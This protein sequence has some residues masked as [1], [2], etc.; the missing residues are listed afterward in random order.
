MMARFSSATPWPRLLSP[1]LLLV[2]LSLFDTGTAR[3]Q[4]AGLGPS[5]GRE[6]MG[7]GYP[8]PEYY[9]ALEVYRSGDLEK[10]MDA[11]DIAV[12]RTR[13]DIN[14]HWI[15]AIPVFAMM[16][17]CQYRLGDLEGAMQ[18]LDMSLKIAIRYRGWLGRPVWSEVL[19]SQFQ[20]SPKQ[21]LW[22]EANAVNR[23]PV[24][25]TIKFYSGEQLTEATLAQGGVI[26]ELNIKPIDAIEILRGLAIA[27]YRRRIILGP[28]AEGDALATQLLDSTKYPAG[29]QLP[30]AR[31]LI[32][33]MRAAER[34][35]AM[36]DERTVSD[37]AENATY[38]GGVHPI[39]PITGL[40]A[41]SALAGSDKPAAAIPLCLAVTNQAASMDYFE[42]VGEALQL[43]AGC[44]TAK[45]AAVVQQAGQVAAT[46]LLRKSRLAALHCLIASADAAVTA[47]DFASATAR[48]GEAKAIAMRRDVLQPRLDAYGAYVAARL[49]TRTATPGGNPNV[50]GPWEEGLSQIF[51]FATNSRIRKRSLI[52]M[53]RLYQLQR[54]RLALGRNLDGQSADVLLASYADDPAI[55]VWRRDPVDAI[56]G[57][58]ADRDLL[59]L[60][61]LRT[62]ASRESGQDVLARIEDL[63]AGRIRS[64]LPLGGRV[65]QVRALA[66]MPDELLEKKIVEF[67]NAADKPIRDLRTAAKAD[68]DAK[69]AAGADPAM[70]QAGLDRL[71]ANAWA[72]ALDR[73]VLPVV[74]P[75]ALD[76]KQPASVLPDDVG[77]L[78]FCQ[79]GNLIHA[80]LC[81]KQKSTYWT[82][83]GASRVA[84]EIAALSRGIGAAPSRG[85]RLPE[86]DGWR[87]DAIKFRDRLIATGTGAL[88][89]GRL[90][91]IK[92]LVVIPD[93]LLW[94]V[95]FELLPTD[96]RD[97]PLLGDSIDVVYAAT[98]A[99]AIYPTADKT[100]SPAIAVT[101]GKFFAP[102]EAET[103]AML[104]QTILD[105]IH[106][107]AAVRLPGDAMIPTSQSGNVAGHLVVAE[108]TTPNPASVL[109]SPLAA[110]ETSMRQGRL[111]SWLGFPPGTPGSVFLAGFRS[112]LDT[113][114][115]VSGHEIMHVIAALQYSG[116]RDVI[117][118]RWA[119][120]GESTAILLREYVQ[121]LP[122]LGAPA[123]LTRAKNV[124]RRSEIS[125]LGEPTLS[126][127]D[128]ERETLTG[129]EP[130]FWST[131][132]HA[133]PL[134]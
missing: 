6:P 106:A 122:F 19:M 32:G 116:V 56:A 128:Q 131:Y 123:A 82:I 2:G 64:Q 100:T 115:G 7:S 4:G 121:E 118:S 42:W 54:V 132:L 93:A 22:P 83:K 72:I 73:T 62:A 13:K 55:D 70:V 89:T 86:D 48:L 108:P 5:L 20:M 35:G 29:L 30:I 43:A 130:F 91:G 51:N 114:Q 24:T 9:F 45:D 117:L 44:A 60:A 105:S 88:L 75:H 8:S 12:S 134:N 23:L 68:L 110:Y 78:A 65:M 11:F 124:L 77:I 28:L 59:R 1:L 103:N 47:G 69:P 127:S 63:Q 81:T 133:S 76:D 38:N 111:R 36:Q 15:D 26:E 87:D 61:R 90:T 71:E 126:G 66:R 49:A 40:C 16:G 80:V 101:A 129:D 17:E 94:Y 50:T 97:A 33:A 57:V 18:S 112:N 25:R 3:G 46:N 85:A 119:V 98:P 109:D 84:G 14:G 67:R 79:D 125:P 74:M 58:V 96:E 102:R 53:P 21:Y 10:A 37:A 34:F 31:N 52:S 92:R 27:S 41:A 95:P 107:G 120:G 104:V 113:S 99:L 39:S